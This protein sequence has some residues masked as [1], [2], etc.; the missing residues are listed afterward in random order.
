MDRKNEDQD[1][2]AKIRSNIKQYLN[3]ENEYKTNQLIIGLQNA[4]Q[5]HIVNSW[6]GSKVIDKADYKYNKVITLHYVEFYFECWVNRNDVY[7]SSKKQQK[8]LK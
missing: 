1:K 4:F 5:G 6:I 3:N 2:I 7:H 8:I